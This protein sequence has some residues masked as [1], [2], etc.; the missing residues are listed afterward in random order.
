MF[1]YEGLGPAWILFGPG[2]TGLLLGHRSVGSS[3]GLGSNLGSQTVDLLPGVQTGVAPSGFLGWGG[4]L[5]PDHLAGLWIG[6]TGPGPWPRVVQLS[7]RAAQRPQWGAKMADLPPGAWMGVSPVGSVDCPGSWPSSAGA[8]QRCTSRFVVRSDF[9]D[10]VI[11][12]TEGHVCSRIP[13]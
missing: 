1:C 5:L 2:Q 9:R 13:W 6:R 12:G 8:G 11:E 3:L 10:F 4:G 7:N